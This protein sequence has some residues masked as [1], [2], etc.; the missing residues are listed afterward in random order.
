MGHPTEI[1]NPAHIAFSPDSQT[2][3]A[4]T[5]LLPIVQS[6]PIPQVGITFW[7]VTTGQAIEQI[8]EVSQFQFSPDGQFLMANGQQVQIWKPYSSLVAAP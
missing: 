3:A 6:E 5:L 4:N 2:L 8:R 1:S 7:D